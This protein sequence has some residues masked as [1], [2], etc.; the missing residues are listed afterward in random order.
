MA[1]ELRVRT[2]M[3]LTA[4]FD[5]YLIN[6]NN[7][8]KEVCGVAYHEAIHDCAVDGGYSSIWTLCG[9]ASVI[10]RP[11]VS[12]YPQSIN[13]AHD[14]VSSVLNRTLRPRL[15]SDERHPAI[16]IMWTRVGPPTG[17]IWTANHFVPLLLQQDKSSSAT[18][19]LNDVR[20]HIL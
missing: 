17:T 18:T 10:K 11:V 20:H 8:F 19:G 7:D 3:E 14:R 13:G 5:A 12:V 6:G 4:F 2:V 15:D 16:Y 9:L 1:T